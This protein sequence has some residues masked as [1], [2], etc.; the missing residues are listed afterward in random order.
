M[1]QKI[2][3]AAGKPTVLGSLDENDSAEDDGGDEEEVNGI[4][5]KLA[6]TL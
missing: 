4:A 3:E 2:L 1:L 6:A 5:D